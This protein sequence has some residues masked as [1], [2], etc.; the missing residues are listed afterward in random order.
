VPDGDVLSLKVPSWHWAMAPSGCG[1]PAPQRAV[2]SSMV[3]WW[4]QPPLT[5]AGFEVLGAAECEVE[6]WVE[7]EVEGGAPVVLALVDG[8]AAVVPCGAAW[9]GAG[10]AECEVEVGAAGTGAEDEVEVSARAAAELV[11]VTAAEL[12]IVLPAA[13]ACRAAKPEVAD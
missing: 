9:D 4:M 6:G 7:C 2:P 5:A 1:S 11:D 12:E 10:V 13:A 3:A 8:A